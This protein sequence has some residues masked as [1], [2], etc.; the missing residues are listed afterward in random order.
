LSLETRTGFYEVLEYG[1]DIIA[2]YADVLKERSEQQRQ[3]SRRRR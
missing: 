1:E 3:A 2:T